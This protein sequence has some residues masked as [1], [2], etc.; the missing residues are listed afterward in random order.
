MWKVSV[1]PSLTWSIEF[2][3]FDFFWKLIPKSN[4]YGIYELKEEE[5][6]PA[7]FLCK[8][9][10]THEQVLRLAGFIKSGFLHGCIALQEEQLT[11]SQQQRVDEH[12][13][14]AF[15]HRGSWNALK[16]SSERP[17]FISCAAFVPTRWHVHMFERYS[18]FFLLLWKQ[19][20][21]LSH[22][23]LTP[24]QVDASYWGTA[25][26][27]DQDFGSRAACWMWS[28]AASSSGP[29]ALTVSALQSGSGAEVCTDRL[30]QGL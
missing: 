1:I 22:A 13:I 25:D 16:I 11:D 7:C 20:H 15:Q 29:G 19:K 12:F 26:K 28:S 23:G 4:L 14:S 6:K 17:R 8:S 27:N 5:K 10:K 21:I 9:C 24:N 3:T 18:C 30:W 2:Y